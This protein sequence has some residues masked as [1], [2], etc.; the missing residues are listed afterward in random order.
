MSRN[1]RG[2]VAAS[3]LS[4]AY[5]SYVFQ[6]FG[7]GFWSAGV[8]D[9]VDP[10]FLNYL[11]EH[12]HR[13][14]LSFSSPWSPPA[15]FPLE[16]VLG[17]CGHP[18]IFYVPFYEVVR[19][20]LHPFVAY[21]AALLLILATGTVFLFLL[22]RKVTA[23]TTLE[24]LVLCAFFLTSKNV[25]NGFTE[26]WSQ[27]ASIFILP[28]ILFLVLRS[29]TRAAAFAGGLA[30]SL[31][32]VHEFYTAFFALLLPVAF[33]P[34]VRRQMRTRQWGL[35][36]MAGAAIGIGLFIWL[37]LPAYRQQPSFPQEQ[38][39]REI[40]KFEGQFNAYESL[41]VFKATALVLLFSLFPW[42][43][44]ERRTRWLIWW[45]ALVSV[46][47]LLVPWR[48][49][50][51][52][53]WMSLFAHLP[54]AGAIRDPKRIIYLYELAA[55]LV[56]AV[57]MAR[58]PKRVR[59]AITVVIVALIATDWNRYR[60]Q[61]QRPI[62]V[63][64]Q[65]VGQPMQIDPSCRSFFIA[66]AS[67]AYSGR[68][69]HQWSLYRIDAMFIAARTGVPTLNGY[70]GVEPPGWELA[71]PYEEPYLSRVGQWIGRNGLTNVCVLDI[72]PRTMRPY[73]PQP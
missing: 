8:G 66:F 15:F 69:A 72:E 19:P 65:W 70:T 5:L 12:W 11:V 2:A 18:L 9:W 47:V 61:Y 3:V 13:S 6:T 29:K 14:I 54:G 63:F 4:L 51:F 36:S 39:L 48:I 20:F 45:F 68:S 43:K 53:I 10:Y 55:V 62:A 21:N 1:A 71:N 17:R 25:I 23:I 64:D 38:L 52:S 37:Y 35:A 58:F 24:A 57:A 16:R 28:P 46:A 7:D 59:I 22:L 34:L 30:V 49:G 42:L 31:L 33:V 67:T 56:I 32:L 50:G 44:S 60:F 41:R 27:R 73:K 26:T 40:R